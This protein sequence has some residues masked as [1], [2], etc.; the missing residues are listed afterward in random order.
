[1]MFALSSCSFFS[2][3][4]LYL[5]ALPPPLA[6]CF[7]PLSTLL[8]PPLFHFPFLLASYLPPTNALLFFAFPSPSSHP[9]LRLSSAFLF[10]ILTS[11]NKGISQTFPHRWVTKLRHITIR[12]VAVLWGDYWGI[13]PFL[14]TLPSWWRHSIIPHLLVYLADRIAR[15]LHLP[16]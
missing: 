10:F 3:Y 2:W 5:Y 11:A 7:I 8:L 6:F 4:F 9:P 1:M 14:S 16:S 13:Q 15:V 12:D